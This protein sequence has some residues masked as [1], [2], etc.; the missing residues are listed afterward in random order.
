MVTLLRKEM[1]SQ[2]EVLTSLG[3]A[4]TN[5]AMIAAAAA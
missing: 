1:A 2:P 3:L 4:V 5:E